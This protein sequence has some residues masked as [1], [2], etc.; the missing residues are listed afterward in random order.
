M[1]MIT[2]RQLSREPARLNQI[3]PGQSVLVPDARG[4]LVVTRPKKSSMSAEQIFA[5]VERLCE[6]CPPIDTLA[7]LREGEE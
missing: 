3:K 4:G 7:F 2:R 6:G 1:K 5:E